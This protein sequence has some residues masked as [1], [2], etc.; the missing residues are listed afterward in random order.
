MRAGS[1]VNPSEVDPV[2]LYKRI[3]GPE[4]KDPNAANFTPDPHTA[5]IFDP[6]IRGKTDQV[7]LRFRKPG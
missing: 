6:T 1:T 4:F 2:S 5:I 3:F 7:V